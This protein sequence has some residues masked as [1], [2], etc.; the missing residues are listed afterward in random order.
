MAR[1][2]KGKV[3]QQIP[4]QKWFLRSEAWK[5]GNRL[6]NGHFGRSGPIIQNQGSG[7]HE[8]QVPTVLRGWLCD[9][10]SKWLKDPGRWKETWEKMYSS[11]SQ[12]F[13]NQILLCY[14][15]PSL[16]KLSN[17]GNFVH[18]KKSIYNHSLSYLHYLNPS[19]ITKEN[20]LQDELRSTTVAGYGS[21]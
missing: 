21:K 10:R 6:G 9:V 12:H 7:L 5:D 16:Y 3:Q 14:I 1:L 15:S 4:L 13:R 19:L 2:W 20:L 17:V 8:R 18:H 11:G